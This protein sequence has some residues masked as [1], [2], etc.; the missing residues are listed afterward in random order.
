MSLRRIQDFK[1]DIN[2]FLSLE[3]KKGRKVMKEGRKEGDKGRK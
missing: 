3:R 1:K 2:A